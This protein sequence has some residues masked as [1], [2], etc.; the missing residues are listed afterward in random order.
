M[1]TV[2]PILTTKTAK[3]TTTTTIII[4]IGVSSNRITII[5]SSSKL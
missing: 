5:I 3:T 2:K 1:I 4:S